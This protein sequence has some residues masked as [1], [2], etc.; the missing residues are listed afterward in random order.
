MNRLPNTAD[1]TQAERDAGVQEI[2]RIEDIVIES[3][4]KAFDDVEAWTVDY[5]FV[6]ERHHATIP[7]ELTFE[8]VWEEKITLFD[9][10][11]I[12]EREAVDAWTTQT[13]FLTIYDWTMR[14]GFVVLLGESA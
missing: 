7:T 12:M 14:G 10:Q 8:Q 2:K 1:L 3:L 6:G 13:G 5:D 11:E 4:T 9:L